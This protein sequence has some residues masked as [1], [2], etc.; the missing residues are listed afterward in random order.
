MNIIVDNSRESITTIH[1]DE[2]TSMCVFIGIV[3]HMM[4]SFNIVYL[5]SQSAQDTKR[6]DIKDCNIL[7]L[8]DF[9]EN[10]ICDCTVE[11]DEL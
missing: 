7:D 10:E 5:T 3:N 4:E 1:F 6:V 8:E 11:Y 9:F 2:E